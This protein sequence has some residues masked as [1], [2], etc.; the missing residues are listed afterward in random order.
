[1]SF[2][3]RKRTDDLDGMIPP[4][5]LKKLNTGEGTYFSNIE[6]LILLQHLYLKEKSLD[7]CAKFILESVTHDDT[8]FLD[9]LYIAVEEYLLTNVEEN[10]FLVPIFIMV[11]NTYIHYIIAHKKAEKIKCVFRDKEWCV[12][13]TGWK[14]ENGDHIFFSEMFQIV[15]V[16]NGKTVQYV[17]TLRKDI[18]LHE[19]VLGKI[20]FVPSDNTSHPPM[21]LGGGSYG[22]AFKIM[23]VDG[24]WY[25]VKV[26]EKKE[27]AEH[28]WSA[29]K[30]VMGKHPC[31]Q[32]GIALET[33]REGDVQHII[34]SKYQGEI[35]L[36][37]I[38]KSNYRITFTQLI[39][40]FMELLDGIDIVHN[41]S[42]LHCD[43]KPDNLIFQVNLES[44]K[45]LRIVLID[46]GIAEN[47]GKKV[48]DPQTHFT[49]W[50]RIPELMCANVLQSMIPFM[51][52]LT[53]S[54]CADLWAF[55]ISILHVLSPPSSDFLGFRS[56]EESEVVRDMIWYSPA[57]QLMLA[58][59]T[60]VISYKKDMNLVREIY[61]ILLKN[62][63]EKKF[64]ETF[65]R[66]GINNLKAGIYNEYIHFFE[67]LKRENPMI[68][69]VKTVFSSVYCEDPSVDIS[70]PIKSLVDL[71]ID[72]LSDG[73]DLSLLGCLTIDHIQQWINRL[74]ACMVDIDNLKRKIFF[75]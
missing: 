72:I 38:R 12:N 3:K 61:F 69:H 48:K 16:N 71:F 29:L 25:A 20:S 36:S 68:K 45:K 10:Q 60:C 58:M 64:I 1:M 22:F 30:I 41:R 42:I 57:S 26:F 75:Y 39:S 4:E 9:E 67:K 6:Y 33:E 55:F 56:R 47:K 37:K 54:R 51:E 46:F 24:K 31:L 8:R 52:P 11:M 2:N 28:E 23:G 32:E 21:F 44:D 43:I 49:S 19:I 70:R 15:L 27:N 63:G 13:I 62:E 35:V 65:E 40:M 18:R 73:R 7:Q 14:I 17:A 5:L 53:L 74:D 50:Y 66:F 34:V 59:K